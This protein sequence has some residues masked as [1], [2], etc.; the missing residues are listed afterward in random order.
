MQE[1]L[2]KIRQRINQGFYGNQY[3]FEADFQLLTYALNDG[4]AQ[5]SAGALSAFSFGAQFEILSAS[6]D[7]KQPPKI[8]FTADVIDSQKEG[9]TPS[10]IKSINGEDPVEFLTKF[11]AL[12]SWGYVE[13]HTEW[14]ALM[15]SPV[16]DIQGGN[17]V[18]SGAA[19]FYPGDNLTVQFENYTA[20]DPTTEWADNWI[21]IYNAAPNA[22]GP[23]ATGG[24]FYNYFVLGLLPA[25]FNPDL[26]ETPDVVEPSPA[27]GNWSLDSWGAFPEDPDVAQYDLGDLNTGYVSGYYYKD[28][29]TGV[30]SLPTFDIVPETVG[31]YTDTIAEFVTGASKAGLSKVIIDLQRNS[32]GLILLAYTTFKLFFPDLSPFAGSRRRNFPLGNLMGSATTK[33]WDSLNVTDPTELNI[34]EALSAE[35]WIITNRIN[36]ATGKNFTSWAE[37]QTPV[38]ANG[39]VFTLTEQYDLANIVFDSAAFDEWYPSMYLPDKSQWAFTERAWQPDQI[40]LLTDGLCSSTCSLFVEMMTRA[41]VRTVVAGGRPQT[42]PMQAVGGNRGAAL[43][44]TDSLD[45][46]MLLARSID[47]FVDDNVNA[48]VPEVRDPGMFVNF[49]SVNLR[50]Q[51]RKDDTTPL[52]FKYEAADCR[53]YYTLANVYNM[54]RLWHDVSAAAFDDSSRCVEGSTGYSTTNNTRPSPPPPPSTVRPTLDHNNPV[55]ELVELEV[56]PPSGLRDTTGRGGGSAFTKCPSDVKIGQKCPGL[57]ATCAEVSVSCEGFTKS[58]KV[59][60]CLPSCN[61]AKTSCTCGGGAGSCQQSSKQEVK[62]LKGKG[63]GSAEIKAFSGTCHPIIGHNIKS[64]CPPNPNKTV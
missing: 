43:Y 44:G 5:L 42:G 37:Y 32:G 1:E 8:W 50:D 64:I 47:E 35:D 10:A 53:I 20:G 12:N 52:Q 19:T 59:R 38:G 4:H 55:V 30:L 34:K 51:V 14:N 48:T 17:T 62:P 33:F 31:N 25:S 23:L 7:G 45:E 39:D 54:T 41:G 29:S 22:T 11:A 3:S 26:I 36:A 57:S 63:K 46:D 28:I 15:S 2:T 40:V 24:D 61:C 60:A 58:Q 18:F 56:D 13:P 21:A 6:A 9:W 49:A 27:P 16:L